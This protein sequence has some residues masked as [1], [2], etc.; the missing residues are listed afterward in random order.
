M[1]N[2][3]KALRLVE[4]IRAH[5]QLFKIHSIQYSVVLFQV[6]DKQGAVSNELTKSVAAKIKNIKEGFCSPTGF[7]G[8]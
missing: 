2:E 1:S 4:K 3:E 8:T 7:R 6:K 5:P